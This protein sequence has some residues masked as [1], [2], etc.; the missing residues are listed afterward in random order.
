MA[1]K[2]ARAVARLMPGCE[3][4][5]FLEANIFDF[6]PDRPFKVVNS[7]GVLHHTPN[8]HAA[9]RQVIKWLAPGG[10]LHLGLYHLYSRRPFLDHFAKLQATGSS[11]AELYQEFKRLNPNI[12]DQT[13]MLSWFRDQVLHPHETQHTYE[14]IH[15][16]LVSEGLVVKATSI[17]NFKNPA[18]L[19]KLIELEQRLEAVSKAALYRQKRYCPGFFVVWARRT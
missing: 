9:I 11:E 2:Q 18:S 12:T 19:A 16:L 17:N 1:L 15:E 10:H 14:E 4:V 6:Q 13:H 8:C 3:D 7:L 5:E